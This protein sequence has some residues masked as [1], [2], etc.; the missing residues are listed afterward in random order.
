MADVITRD[1]ER[2][3][4]PERPKGAVALADESPDELPA[5]VAIAVGV[6]VLAIAIVWPTIDPLN[7]GDQADVVATEVTEEADGEG[8]TEA[9]SEESEEASTGIDLPAIVVG[10]AGLGFVDLGLSA[11]GAVVTATGEV[12]DEATRGQVLDFIAGQPGV[13]SVTDQLTIAAA[14]ADTVQ[15]DATVEAAQA[16][17]I[18]TG[19]V[20]DQATVDAIVERVVAVYSEEQVDNRLEVDD[21]RT[22]PTQITVAGAMTDPVLF[23]QISTAFDDLD[24]VEV[25]TRSIALEEPSELE[26]SLNTLEPIQFAS[27][28]AIIQPE[29]AEILDEAAAF[30]NDTPGVAV[31]IG[32]HTDSRGSVE[33]NQALSQARA[34]AVKAA[35]EERGVTNDLRSVGFG[36]RRLRVDPDDT[37]EAQQENRRI[38]FRL[39]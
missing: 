33:S 20:P 14:E 15:G 17:V 16:S 26:S 12:A 23:D 34:D 30:L 6:A 10:L 22:V 37:P 32:G 19:T 39:L 2:R 31:E 35:L 25:A 29:S 11:D 13:E 38:E 9:S 28:S 18:L 27:G 7:Q 21:T 8:D 3:R 24:G 5:L 36:E 4:E 1:N